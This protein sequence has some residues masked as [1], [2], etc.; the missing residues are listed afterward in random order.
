MPPESEHRVS[1]SSARPG[2]L[3]SDRVSMPGPRFNST[4]SA[5]RVAAQSQ[6]PSS[7]RAIGPA[8][9]PQLV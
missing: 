5:A 3:G 2:R 1:R 4:R 6:L 8:I 9:W 7:G